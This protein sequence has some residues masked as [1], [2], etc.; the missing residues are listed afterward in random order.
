MF[1][2]KNLFLYDE[3]NYIND[4]FY[5]ELNKNLQI[6]GLISTLPIGSIEIAKLIRPESSLK[7]RV[8]HNKYMHHIVL[9][10]EDIR[11]PGKIETTDPKVKNFSI[12]STKLKRKVG[13][14]EKMPYQLVD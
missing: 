3:S 11:K 10:L 5:K 7:F 2:H 14:K 12:L 8:L 6:Y 4:T 13:S 1:K 9:Q